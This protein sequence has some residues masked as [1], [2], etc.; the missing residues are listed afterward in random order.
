MP[1]DQPIDKSTSQLPPLTV[2]SP[3]IPSSSP[4]TPPQT[5]P[6][7]PRSRDAEKETPESTQSGSAAPTVSVVF[8]GDINGDL[9]LAGAAS[10]GPASIDPDDSPRLRSL[11]TAAE[12]KE[13]NEHMDDVIPYS[14]KLSVSTMLKA[15]FM[16]F[17]CCGGEKSGEYE[18]LTQEVPRSP[19][20]KT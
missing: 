1:T 13:K 10:T 8:S 14:P 3:V 17:L 4:K 9:S 15:G 2:H 7:A 5:P 19:A 20:V 12:Q 6:P 11:R 18:V 16:K